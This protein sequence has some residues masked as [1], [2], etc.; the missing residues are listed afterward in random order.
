MTLVM[1]PLHV[2]TSQAGHAGAILCPVMEM[3]IHNVKR[4]PSPSKNFCIE[5][6]CQI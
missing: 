2:M 4:E 5:L 1:S 6:F 3:Y